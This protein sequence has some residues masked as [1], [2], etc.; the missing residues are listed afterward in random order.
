[1][2][3]L[4]NLYPTIQIGSDGFQWWIGQIESKK[5]TDKKSS[6]RYK[7]R[8]VGMHPQTCDAV[9]SDDL[10]WA[11]TMMPVTNPHIPGGVASVSDQLQPG[12]WVIGFFMDVDKQQP[13]IMGSIGQVAASTTEAPGEDPTP[14]ESGCKS[15][16]TFL[17][18][19]TKNADQPTATG[20]T[21]ASVTAVTAG[22][23]VTGENKPDANGNLIDSA[24]N[25]L[26]AAKDG[27]NS[28]SNPG[29][30]NWCIEIADKCGKE[31]D[32]KGTFT[33]LLGEMLYETQR[34][35]GK[36]GTYLVGELSGEL[37]DAIAIGKKYVNK[38]IRVVRTF[39]ASI[40]GFIL[41]KLKAGIKD[42]TNFLLG[43]TPTGNSL[44][45][46]T[47]FFNDILSSVGC[48]IADLGDRIAA[49]I[50]DLLF[51]YLFEIYK[52]AACQI[53]ALVEGILNKI[54]SELD[55]L[56]NQILGPI[57]DILGA[58]A[59]AID[60]IGDVLAYVMDILGIKCS[61]PPKECSKTTVVCTDCATDKKGDFLD[62]L[63][64]SITDDLFPVTGEDWS[65]YTCAEASEGTTIKD[66]EVTLVGGTQP[67]SSPPVINYSIDD[68]VVTEGSGATFTVTRTGYIDVA[69]SVTYKTSDGTAIENVDYQKTEGILGFV[70][71]E[72]SKTITV[73]TYADAET[74]YSETFYVTIFKE[75][76]ADVTISAQKNI[77]KCIIKESPI[78]PNIST[79]DEEDKEIPKPIVP[80]SIYNPDSPLVTNLPPPTS[81][82]SDGISGTDN[83]PSK[84]TPSYLVE[85]DKNSVKE[86]EYVKFTITTK[87]VPD[88]KVLGYQIF[89]NN[90]TADDI[91]SKS[92]S[93]S[94]TIENGI[95]QVTVGIAVDADIEFNE[96]LIFGIPGTGAKDSV[97][98]LGELDSLSLDDKLGA[99]D[100]SSNID[101]NDGIPK[102]PVIG[103]PITDPGGGIIEL[104][105]LEPGDP[106][107]IPPF[108]IVT[109][110]GTGAS[111]IALLDESGFLSEI[112]VT[113]PGRSYRLNTPRKAVKEC[114]IDSFTLLNTGRNYTSP[115]TVYINGDSSIAEAQIN[116]DGLVISVR[117]KNRELTFDRYPEVLIIGGGGYGAK[118]LPSFS[119]LSPE[120]RVI[121]GSAKIG[122]GKYIDCP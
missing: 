111:A 58:V 106:Y 107:T 53:D 97:V 76:P 48:E 33:R 86:G 91:L 24:T 25:N 89:G 70:A 87:N 120:D 83:D 12:V 81:N 98:I 116:D 73:Q 9:S 13:V 5:S 49:F 6:G 29:G 110:N 18:P 108:V 16:T 65:Q 85:A 99:L 11:I 23:V 7:V 44:S 117:I 28:N 95:A 113:N 75:T 51:G 61:G 90:I 60:I 59:S 4:S 37:N 96:T 121:V 102:K 36:L 84:L 69:S 3:A 47:K 39:V 52:A 62:D 14:G 112:R 66:T 79:G 32:L 21:T 63:I 41:E 71:G 27:Q 109:G 77:G 31:K 30:T 20:K 8:I 19:D 92:L 17:S 115:P 35:G 42:L 104:P 43:V 118:A 105:I 57:Q 1:M 55:K 2:D 67:Y 94:F 34:N 64:E 74:D 80:P 15:F 40:K 88:G 10:P 82:V 68:P 93:G 100:S 56:L 54:Q 22:H 119:C 46:V 122:T 38:G 101:A 45:P 114:I 50:Q 103:P 26:I 78:S 72:T